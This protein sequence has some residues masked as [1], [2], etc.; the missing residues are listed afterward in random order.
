LKLL[1]IFLLLLISI[2]ALAYIGPGAGI[3]VL[4]SVLGILVTI[5][6]AIGAILLWPIRR[7]MK[8]RKAAAD[9]ESEPSE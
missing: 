3:S 1:G 8:R 7:M 2:P 6:V 5:I 9:R 4:G